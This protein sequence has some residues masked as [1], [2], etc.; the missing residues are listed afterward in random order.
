[1]VAYSRRAIDP[2]KH[3]MFRVVTDQAQQ[4]RKQNF[5]YPHSQTS[6]QIQPK[7][8]D[9]EAAELRASVNTAFADALYTKPSSNNNH[10]ELGGQEQITT[11]GK[12]SDGLRPP[13][14]AELSRNHS[15]ADSLIDLYRQTK[16]SSETAMSTPGPKPMSAK[17][18]SQ[19][20]PDSSRWIHRDKLTMIEIQE[21]RDR[22]MEVPPE[23][24]NRAGMNGGDY[25]KL[26][27]PSASLP[28]NGDSIYISKHRRTPSLPKSHSRSHSQSQT[29]EPEALDEDS[30]SVFI[31]AD[32]RSPEEIEADPFEEGPNSPMDGNRLRSAS[33]RI[34]VSKS[35]PLPVG[36]GHRER[37]IPLQRQR[38]PSET[39]NTDAIRYDNSARARSQSVGSQVLLDDGDSSLPASPIQSSPSKPRS[40]S[41]TLPLNGKGSS[42]PGTRKTSTALRNVSGTKA[43][44]APSRNSPAQR[45]TTRDGR[46]TTAV[47]RPEGDP[48]WLAT[49]YQPDPRLPPDQ[50]IIPT[51]AKRMMQEQWE[52]EGKPAGAFDTQ[53]APLSIQTATPPKSSE[54]NK[55]NAHA[56]PSGNGEGSVP[57]RSWPL[58]QQNAGSPEPKEVHAGYKTMP[59]VQTTPQLNSLP[60]PK[61]QR[62]EQGFQHQMEMGVPE[63]EQKKEKEGGCGCCVIM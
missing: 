35:S 59:K 6:E 16:S 8:E 53:F 2:Y 18:G 42:T 25:H 26:H 60:S 9:E 46:P 63:Q 55:E 54:S 29:F 17:H 50:Q 43:T 22:G 28:Q 12:A 57:E 3:K 1:M 30:S 40:P 52:K 36:Q 20:G 13:P 38:G 45:P 21:Y 48:P 24:L 11:E 32:P 27:S 44:T 4:S 62:P 61:L 39:W 15:E 37:D 10:D 49:T 31:P 47:N 41:K 33:S 51:H 7:T 5:S 58:K 23:L 14:P 19:E 34:P 56:G